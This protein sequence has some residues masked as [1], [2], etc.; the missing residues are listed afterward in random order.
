[1]TITA[2]VKTLDRYPTRIDSEPALLRRDDPVVY[3]EPGDGPIRE[4]EL[5]EFDQNGFLTLADLLSP[6]EVETYLEELQ[7]LDES[8][9]VKDDERAILEPET[10]ELRSLFEAHRVSEVFAKLVV[11]HRLRDRVEQILGSAVYVHQSRV[12]FEPGFSG[13][14]SY[15]HADFETW[16]AEDGMPA[17]RAVGVSLA[18]T[19]NYHVNGPLMIMPGS[20]RTFV[21]CVDDGAEVRPD[22]ISLRTL[23]EQSGVVDFAGQSGSAVIFDAN[24]IHGANSNITAFPRSTVLIVF[25]SVENTLVDPYAGAPARPEHLASRSFEPLT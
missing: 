17:P 14:E 4:S 8:V 6:E 10:R 1:M 9:E 23:V 7:R 13:K 2:D 11:D 19:D 15:W 18:L 21:K 20:H 24:A 16:H 3:G 22:P 12:D 5:D 25:N